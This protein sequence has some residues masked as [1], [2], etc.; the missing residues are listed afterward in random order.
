VFLSVFFA[1]NSVKRL[2][3]KRFTS[4]LWGRLLHGRG[5]I[6]PK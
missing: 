1:Q 2:T 3:G 4:L 6:V 5:E